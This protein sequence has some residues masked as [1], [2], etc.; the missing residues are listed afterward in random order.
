MT[1]SPSPT[2][3]S[4]P[5]AAAKGVH[6]ASRTANSATTVN[7]AT[8]SSATMASAAA[9]WP[10]GRT[11]S[12]FNPVSTTMKATTRSQRSSGVSDGNQNWRYS[13]KRAGYTATSTKLSIQLHQ[14]TW[15]DQY[16]PKAWRV[17]VT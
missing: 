7:S 10:V 11:P 2:A 8:G 16:G 14:P 3:S 1:A 15:N 9:A 4:P 6:G 5:P 12:R 17:Q 13:T